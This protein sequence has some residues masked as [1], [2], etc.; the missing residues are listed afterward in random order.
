MY[1][2]YTDDK[3]DLS[4]RRHFKVEVPAKLGEKLASGGTW[5]DRAGSMM[6]IIQTFLWMDTRA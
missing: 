4:Q 6:A 5:V 2:L 1:H 3:T